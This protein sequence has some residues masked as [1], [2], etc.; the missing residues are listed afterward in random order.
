MTEVR[1]A[2]AQVTEPSL[3]AHLEQRY[4]AAPFDAGLGL[5]WSSTC[6]CQRTSFARAGAIIRLASLGLSDLRLTYSCQSFILFEIENSSAR[7]K[8]APWRRGPISVRDS[9]GMLTGPSHG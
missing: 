3:Q 8:R 6:V 7:L 5:G 9:Q 1:W 2:S 4:G